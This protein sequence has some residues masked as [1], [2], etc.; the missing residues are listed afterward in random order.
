[1]GYWDVDIVNAQATLLARA[2]SDP[3]EFPRLHEYVQRREEVLSSLLNEAALV[4]QGQQGRAITRDCV[5]RLLISMMN[6]GG[7]DAWAEAHNLTRRTNARK[8]QNDQTDQQEHIGSIS[9]GGVDVGRS[10]ATTTLRQR[11]VFLDA[12]AS[13]MRR[14]AA[15]EAA[16][17]PEA[18]EKLQQDAVRSSSRKKPLARLMRRL[19][20]M[21]ER[22]VIDKAIEIVEALGFTVIDY[23]H[24]GFAVDP[25]EATLSQQSKQDLERRLCE[26]VSE[27]LGDGPP[28]GTQGGG[29][30]GGGGSGGGGVS[31]RFKISEYPSVDE[32]L[33]RYI[34][35]EYG[36]FDHKKRF[37]VISGRD[38]IQK[39]AACQKAIGVTLTSNE[40]DMHFGMVYAGLIE[41]IA[42]RGDGDRLE[43]F[44]EKTRHWELQQIDSMMYV[45]EAHGS[46]FKQ[47]R[48]TIDHSGVL[49]VNLPIPL[50]MSTFVRRVMNCI[51]RLLPS[52]PPASPP[53]PRGERG[54]T[55]CSARRWRKA[56]SRRRSIVR[57]KERPLS[58]STW[59]GP[60]DIG[61]ESDI[62]R[63][64]DIYN[65][66]VQGRVDVCVCVCV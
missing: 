44:N 8:D 23:Q 40:C 62:V 53:K 3:G 29:G 52:S 30:S 55:L 66:F 56:P 31:I 35:E 19:S 48:H 59:R 32:I 18:Y 33:H 25:A 63:D 9:D 12:F 6:L 45:L 2:Y 4:Y 50:N 64:E 51:R 27:E 39:L 21:R 47:R 49:D 54:E 14:I 43:Y 28:N 22:K 1:L 61:R 26:M 34:P 7:E 10:G 16:A 36:A 13:E 24:D 37:R 65:H 46:V 41:D 58:S 20:N 15:L 60:R 5:K 57:E 11:S 17:N 42:Y 38:F